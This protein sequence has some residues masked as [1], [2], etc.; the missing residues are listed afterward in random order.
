M[1]LIDKYNNP[2]ILVEKS[3]SDFSE[4]EWESIIALDQQ[5]FRETYPVEDPIPGG[6]KIK[7][8]KLTS[9]DTYDVRYFLATRDNTFLGYGRLNYTN[10][11]SPNFKE[12][13]H[14]VQCNIRIYSEFRRHGIGKAILK[15][16]ITICRNL[17]K[18]VLQGDVYLQSAVD[19]VRE[20]LDAE[21]AKTG[22]ENRVYVHN[23]DWDLMRSWIQVRDDREIKIYEIIPDEIID[24]FCA[25]YNTTLDREPS[26]EL[27]E[28]FILT[29]DLQRK[30]EAQFKQN[31]KVIHNAV[32]FQDDSIVG[33]T[34]L[35]YDLKENYY[36][37][38][39]LTGVLTE[40]EG[41]GLGKWLKA[42][43]LLHVSKLYPDIKFVRA[44][45]AST[46][47]PMLSI[48]HRMGF[49]RV[50]QRFDYNIHLDKH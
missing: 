4:A 42:A 8:A 49:K 11:T 12:N 44:G 30:Y 37:S 43:L 32:A 25:V 31:D 5:V 17:D 22:D 48:N 40:F 1:E 7:K 13:K 24:E 47:Q 36:I 39:G 35:F 2:F 10:Q 34:E 15:Y 45:N 21:P 18:T 16:F 20:I 33:L 27:E 19:F 6:E 9:I 23:I 28:K 3:A 29:P 38:Q 46:N 14:I 41:Q 26:G 50:F